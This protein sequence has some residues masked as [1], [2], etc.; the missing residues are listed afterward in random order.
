V[1]DTAWLVK[2]DD[3]PAITQALDEICDDMPKAML[4]AEKC[5]GRFLAQYSYGQVTPVLQD[6]VHG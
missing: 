2:P 4:R 6:A 5:R 1:G 3:V